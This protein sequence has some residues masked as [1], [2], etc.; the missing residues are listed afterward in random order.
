MIGL[1]GETVQIKDG[2]I[3]IDG[4][5][6]KE[7]LDLEEIE[8]EGLA[9]NGVSLQSGEYFVLETTGITARTAGM[10]ISECEETIHC[11]ETV[12]RHVP[13]QRDRFCKGLEKMNVQ[14]YPGHMTKAKR[15]DAG[16]YQAD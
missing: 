16:R 5:L 14:W 10:Q 2:Q 3:Y 7:S 9:E 6:Y 15:N 8:N 12:V 13:A 11:G 1:P 4:D